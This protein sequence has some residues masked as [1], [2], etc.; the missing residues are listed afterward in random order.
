[1]SADLWRFTTTTGHW[2]RS[3]R[4]AVPDVIVD[5]LRRAIEAARTT[6]GPV[7]VGVG[8]GEL[9]IVREGDGW[10]AFSVSRKGKLLVSCAVYWTVTGAG[11]AAALLES[12]AAEKTLPG[13]LVRPERGMDAHPGSAR[14]LGDAEGIAWAFIEEPL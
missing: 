11:H 12:A 3:P 6:R 2:H 5:D 7:P 4:S 8:H 10:A 9:R 1:M 13:L 14:W